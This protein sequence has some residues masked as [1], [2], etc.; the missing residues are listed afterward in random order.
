MNK[1]EK[2]IKLY[3]IYHAFTA[4][5]VFFIPID[6]L[7]L[8]HV[9]NLSAS[10]ITFMNMF[11]LLVCILFQKPVVKIAKKIGNLLS[12]RLGIVLLFISTLFLTFSNSMLGLLLYRLISEISVMFTSMLH[13]MIKHNLMSIRKSDDFVKTMSLGNILYAI[14][15]TITTLI[16][17]YIYNF[18]NYFP[19][20]ITLF[21]LF[22]MFFVTFSF[23]DEDISEDILEADGTEFKKS[24]QLIWI[25][26][27]SSLF[28]ALYRIGQTN[29]KLF[30]QYDLEANLS[31]EKV[32][33]YMTYI[34]FISRLIRVASCALFTKMY[35]IFKLKIGN[36]MA[37]IHFISFGLMLIGHYI[38]NFTVTVILISLGYFLILVVRDPY[39]TYAEDLILKNTP[40]EH[41]QQMIVKMEAYRKIVQLVLNLSL[42]LVLLKYELVVTQFIFLVLTFIEVFLHL[43]MVN[44]LKQSTT[45]A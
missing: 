28:V 3:P 21:L 14:V 20:Y 4:D 33:I 6:T 26:I 42:T 19:L 13:I 5:L 16:G 31:L 11:G 34:M 38:N 45:K 40:K 17:G 1:T 44:I 37:I 25:I 12:V 24:Y 29:S 32:T 22:G 10:K 8:S 7:F 9:K 18:N 41:Q 43:K 15:T 27:A 2:T 36:I 39:Q 35:R 23:I 30:L